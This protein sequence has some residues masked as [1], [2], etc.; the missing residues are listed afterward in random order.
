MNSKAEN[1][2]RR[3][4]HP[5]SSSPNEETVCRVKSWA[6]QPMTSLYS[7]TMVTSFMVQKVLGFM[8]PM[9][10]CFIV[11]NII[12]QPQALLIFSALASPNI[13]IWLLLGSQQSFRYHSVIWKTDIEAT[14]KKQNKTL[15]KSKTSSLLQ[16]IQRPPVLVMWCRTPPWRTLCLSWALEVRIQLR[17]V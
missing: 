11:F 1:D 2:L 4:D 7:C 13:L 5:A 12:A 8:E 14:I 3:S 17:V 16:R 10:P 6:T 9:C 15:D